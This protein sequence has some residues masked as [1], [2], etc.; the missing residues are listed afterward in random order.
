M[1]R[2]RRK[3]ILEIENFKMSLIEDANIKLQN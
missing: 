2:E 1:K 3:S